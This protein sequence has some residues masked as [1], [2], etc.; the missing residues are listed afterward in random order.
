MITI[1]SF[2]ATKDGMLRYAEVSYDLRT[3]E[4]VYQCN[5]RS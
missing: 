1:L 5:N 4:A 3:K 2:I